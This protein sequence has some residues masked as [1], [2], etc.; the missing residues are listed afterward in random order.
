MF[1]LFIIANVIHFY[2]FF[3]VGFRRIR[4]K[5]DLIVI[6]GKI[7]DCVGSVL[8]EL[9]FIHHKRHTHPKYY[10]DIMMIYGEHATFGHYTGAI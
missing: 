9:R 7:D 3:L 6:L 5:T 4:L 10:G 2:D 1:N 8:L